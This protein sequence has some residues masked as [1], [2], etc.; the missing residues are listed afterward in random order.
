MIGNKIL[1]IEKYDLTSSIN[2][3]AKHFPRERARSMVGTISNM[4]NLVQHLFPYEKFKV[5]LERWHEQ[6]GQLDI[7]SR[8]FQSRLTI[9][10]LLIYFWLVLPV[11]KTGIFLFL[12]LNCLRHFEV[13]LI[14]WI[15]LQLSVF[16]ITY[17]LGLF[18]DT[19]LCFKVSCVWSGVAF[20]IHLLS[21]FVEYK[22]QR[23]SIL[24]PLKSSS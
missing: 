4:S 3:S 17:H 21:T 19:S 15:C 18:H 9:L 7:L 20:P 5:A 8:Y 11:A 14:P 24:D 16:L 10:F 6:L 12:S 23:Q 2:S 13:M 1:I 22:S